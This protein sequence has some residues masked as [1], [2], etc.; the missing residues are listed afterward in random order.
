MSARDALRGYS[1][2][3]LERITVLA[4]KKQHA[5]EQ[6]LKAVRR[7]VAARVGSAFLAGAVSGAAAA[8]WWLLR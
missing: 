1:K 2:N 7:G 3:E 5:A 8:S 4:A 6:A